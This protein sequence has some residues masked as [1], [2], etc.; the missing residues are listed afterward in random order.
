MIGL[1]VTECTSLSQAPPGIISIQPAGDNL[2]TAPAL[3]CFMW[4]SDW[5]RR[6]EDWSRSNV[7]DTTILL[8][9]KYT[10]CLLNTVPI[11]LSVF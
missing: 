6:L 7:D 5:Q 8:N 9:I 10:S 4:K 2:L 3:S 1:N 11:T